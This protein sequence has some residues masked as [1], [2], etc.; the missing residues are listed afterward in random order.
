MTGGDIS[1]HLP[2]CPYSLKSSGWSLL[3]SI[4]NVLKHGNVFFALPQ[5][6]FIGS[7]QVMLHSFAAACRNLRTLFAA[8]HWRLNHCVILA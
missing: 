1:A 7:Q 6:Y 8:S 3:V 2:F 4:F 5:L